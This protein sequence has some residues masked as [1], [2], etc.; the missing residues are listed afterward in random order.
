MPKQKDTWT[1]QAVVRVREVDEVRLQNDV[2]K[3][4]KVGRPNVCFPRFKVKQATPSKPKSA[5]RLDTESLN[6]LTTGMRFYKG[7]QVRGFSVYKT[8][9]TSFTTGG[10]DWSLN[11]VLLVKLNFHKLYL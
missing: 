2:T 9:S 6:Y 11:W 5:P 1:Y 3:V 8:G 10:S 4:R 7:T